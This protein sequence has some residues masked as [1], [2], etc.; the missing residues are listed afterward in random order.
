[1]HVTSTFVSVLAVL[2]HGA[3]QPLLHVKDSETSLST[4]GSPLLMQ[5]LAA[6]G[7]KTS[8]SQK[9]DP[10]VF[11]VSNTMPEHEPRVIEY[12]GQRSNYKLCKR[13]E[14]GRQMG[15]VP[16]RCQHVKVK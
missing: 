10:K 11:E 7:V 3:A 16:R 5:R 12:G 14:K 9:D 15:T 4:P 2:L 8:A 13:C 1:M 6:C